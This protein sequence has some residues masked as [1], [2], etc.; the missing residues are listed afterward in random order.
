MKPPEKI[1]PAALDA[2]SDWRGGR[3]DRREFLR[4]AT[5]LGVSAPAAL[6]LSGCGGEEAV[7][8][9]AGAG[10]SGVRRGGSL[11]VGSAVQ[12]V[13]HPARLSWVE[14]ANQLRQVAEYLT[15]TGPDN[16]TR[17]WL[18]ERW[19]AD[20]E[21]KTWTLYVRKGIRFNNGEELNADDVIFNFNQWLDPDTGSSVLGLMSYLDRNNIEKVDDHT[22]RLHLDVSQIAV[23][24]HLFHYPALIMHRGFEGD[25][26]KRPVGTGPFELAE[27]TETER[28]ILKRREGYW[29]QGADGDPLPYLDEVIYLDLEP[30]ARAAAMQSGQ[31]D[32][33]YQPRP[34]DWQ[35]LKG[36]PGLTVRP[37]S[38]AQTF[39]LRMRVDLE[40]WTDVRVRNALK[41]CQDR[42]RIL[43]LA[44]FGQGDPGIDAH[45]APVHPA[46]CEKPMP[47][48]DPEKARALLAEAGHPNGLRVKLTTKNDM[49]EPEMAQ[50]LKEMAAP[51]GFEIDLEIV[52]PSHY[53]DRWTE[54]D[55]GITTWTHRPLG[56]MVLALEY[57]AAEEGRPAPWNETR[58]VDG[59]FNRL[60]REAERTLDVDG[61]RQVMCRIEEIMQ[62]RGP[63]GVPFWRKV[64]NITRSEFKNVKAHPTS[65]DLFY[66][67]WKEA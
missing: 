64:W 58:W 40:P 15:E 49:A 57:T 54:V 27:Y 5:L 21:V 11:K 1:H 6:A 19:E 8:K 7:E 30:D 13:D 60:L 63:I 65:Y 12:R 46:F 34:P 26:I 18:L 37:V 20:A 55:L 28:A 33:I 31:I 39:V 47:A 16:L 67:V 41:L 14:G 32:S 59:E 4:F 24:E 44:Y 66:D 51:G 48:Y 38:T 52:E 10:P 50:A 43:Q 62:E 17:P 53:W 45:V 23:P 22:V 35:A 29:R 9:R 25:F 56:T 61:R 3:M 2:Q 36:A 42:E